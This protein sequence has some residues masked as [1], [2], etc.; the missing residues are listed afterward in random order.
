MFLKNVLVNICNTVAS[1]WKNAV[2]NRLFRN[3]SCIIN[4]TAALL[5]KETNITMRVSEINDSNQMLENVGG[6]I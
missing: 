6:I 1:R 5:E 4:L 2:L 3:L